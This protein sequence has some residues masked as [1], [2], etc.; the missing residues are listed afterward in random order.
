MKKILKKLILI[1]ILGIIFLPTNTYAMQILIES[2]NGKNIPLEVESSDTIEAVKAKIY[3]KE[4]IYE[5]NQQLIYQ[6][7]ILEE[8]RTLADYGI[9]KESIIHLV[10]KLLSITIEESEFGVV[11]S[12]VESALVN[13]K[14]TLKITPDKGY[15]V[16]KIT[17]F[18]DDDINTIVEVTNNEFIMPK[19]N[20]RV[21]VTYKQ[22]VDTEN[23][24]IKDEIEEI[25]NPNTSDT[26][27]LNLLSI[28]LSSIILLTLIIKKR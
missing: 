16:D 15:E 13:E 4:G 7:K 3:D 18:K 21:C 19:Y 27:K 8:G 6:E 28:L 11:T 22:I 1:F 10:Y 20:V 25:T 2:E 26:T 5:I 24:S 9:Q 23:E 14:I 17:V 12:N